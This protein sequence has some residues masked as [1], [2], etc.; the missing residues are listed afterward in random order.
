MTY[1]LPGP[2][3]PWPA[4]RRPLSVLAF[5]N[6]VASLMMPMREDRAQGTYVEVLAD[7][8]SGEGVPT[9]AHQASRWFDFLHHAMDDYETR[10]RAHSPDVVIVQFGLNEYQPWL[11]PI[12]LLRILM[13]HNQA[14]TRTAKAFR[15][16]VAPRLWRTV[17]N[18]RRHAA[19]V[20]GMRTWQTTPYRFAGHLRRLLRNL[21]VDG[22]PLVLVLD[23]DCPDPRLEYFLPGMRARRDV[24][25]ALLERV[26]EEQADTHCRLV[27]VSEVTAALGEGALADGMHYSASTHHAVGE[28][29]AQEVLRWLRE[30]GLT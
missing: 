12:W 14:S 19:K 1:P 9:V 17:R 11:L 30:R 21:R 22:R 4:Q 10:V 23:I 29:L 24:F 6:S 26:V 25:Q 15:R 8:L 16:Y 27:R 7:I 28:H 13:V 20:V 2:Q 18:Y 5:G 3:L